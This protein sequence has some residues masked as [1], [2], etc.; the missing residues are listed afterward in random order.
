MYHSLALWVTL[1]ALGFTSTAFAQNSAVNVRRFAISKADELRELLGLDLY[2][3]VF[4][5]EKNATFDLVLKEYQNADQEPRELFRHKF[6]AREAGDVS[7]TVSF[8]KRD[9]TIGSALLSD[10]KEVAFR[11]N[12][13]GCDQGGLATNVRL[14]MADIK[15]KSLYISTGNRPRPRSAEGA[16]LLIL[17]RNGDKPGE[18]AFPY[19]ELSVVPA[20]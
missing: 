11:V 20:K 13:E 15:E 1:A 19:A 2:K 8:L 7:L 3:Y 14:P 17:Q 16:A 5:Q 18:L 10:H 12:A 6:T 9:N 4:L